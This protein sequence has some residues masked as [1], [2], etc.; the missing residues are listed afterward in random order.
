[1]GDSH[2]SKAAPANRGTT[3]NVLKDQLYSLNMRMLWAMQNHNEE[4]QEEIKKQM[5]AVQEEID[6]MC[7]RGRYQNR[8]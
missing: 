5:A 1:M 8:N 6:R 3:L 7:L 2:K 4:A